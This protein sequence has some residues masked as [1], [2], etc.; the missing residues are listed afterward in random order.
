MEIYL[1]CL[2]FDAVDGFEG[3]WSGILRDIHN[4]NS[5]DFFH[6]KN[7]LM[8]YQGKVLFSSPCVG[9]AYRQPDSSP[10][11]LALSTWLGGASGSSTVD[12]PPEIHPVLTGGK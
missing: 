3:S 11:A 1:T 6:G 12:A 9:G 7:E 5:Y 8:Y 2:V 4:G 10:L